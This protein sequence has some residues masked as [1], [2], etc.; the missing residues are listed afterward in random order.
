MTPTARWS[1]LILLLASP[2]AWALGLGD[3]EL[4]SGLNQPLRAE[5]QL[6]SATTE[7]FS[8]LRVTLADQQTFERYGLDRP[9]FLTGISFDVGSNN[10]GSP[11]VAV[12]SQEP[13]AEPFVTVLVEASWSRGRILR[14]YTV[15]LDPP[16]LLPVPE[17][18]TSIQPAETAVSPVPEPA[19][20]INRPAPVTPP[21]QTA[22]PPVQAAS[23]P[24]QPEPPPVSAATLSSA[25][26]SYGPVQSAETLWSIAERYRPPGIMMN[27]MMV[28]LYRANPQ[29]FG[30][31]MNTLHQGVTLRI[32]QS[33]EF[34][35]VT[36]AAAT[37]EALRQNEIWQGGVDQ[38]AR[39]R[40]VTPDSVAA[41]GASTTASA[42]ADSSAGAGTTNS[43]AAKVAELERELG[44]LREELNERGTGCRRRVRAGVGCRCRSRI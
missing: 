2:G 36:A 3:I 8:S 25:S 41:A 40:L 42:S 30:G 34:S 12:S 35:D 37:E 1:A 10:V 19:A 11:V 43:A 27:Q 28:A 6:V 22:P 4:G 44:A 20:A 38:Q 31:N 33:A 14:E 7:E 15:L 13:V 32:P 39:L 9:A 23:P 29:A 26:A 17:V 18:A 16:V 24:P 5:I 21:V